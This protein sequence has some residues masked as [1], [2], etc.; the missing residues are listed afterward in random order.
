VRELCGVR[1][2]CSSGWSVELF[3]AFGEHFAVDLGR[4]LT[5]WD[6][7]FVQEGGPGWEFIV[8]CSICT[9]IGAVIHRFTGWLPFWAWGIVLIPIWV[10]PMRCWPF[11]R[12]AELNA[13]TLQDLVD[14]AKAGK[15]TKEIRYRELSCRWVWWF[16]G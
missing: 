8:G 15:W 3:H 12:G 14:A 4:L 5:A 6:E 13:V 9:G 7:H 2:E 10:W 1:I 11:S 16:G